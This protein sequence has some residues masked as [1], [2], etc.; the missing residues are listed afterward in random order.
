MKRI[1]DLIL[2]GLGLI[3]LSPFFIFIAIGIKLDSSGPVF[4]KQWRVGKNDKDFLLWKFRTMVSNAQKGG[5]ITVGG[6]DARVTAIGYY[7]RKFKLDEVPQL[8]NVVKGD[9][10][11][12]GPRPEVRYYVNLYNADQ[13]TIL[14]VKPGLTD[15]ASLKFADENE[16]LENVKDP[17]SYYS[18]EILPEKI[19][20]GHYYIRK[21]S[22]KT[23]FKIMFRTVLSLVR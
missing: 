10:A 13:R 5:L 16:L 12:V 17:E 4:F 14:A 23:D 7:L 22:V 19:E 1:I 21:M 8:I 9:M 6:R 15:F 11:L 18:N 3:I 20:L 2:G